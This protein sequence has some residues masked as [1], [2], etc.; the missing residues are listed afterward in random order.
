MPLLEERGYDIELWSWDFDEDLA[1][2][3]KVKK[4]PKILGGGVLGAL[5]FAA[6]SFP[7]AAI[8]RMRRRSSG[9][10]SAIVSV[11]WLCPLA[12]VAIYHFFAPRWAQ[13]SFKIGFEDVRELGRTILTFPACVM[14]IVQANNPFCGARGAVS[15]SVADEI[16]GAT[17]GQRSSEKV[18]VLPNTYDIE[19]FNPVK[20]GESRDKVR[21]EL[22]LAD[23]AVVTGFCSQG[24]HRRKGFW[25]HVKAVK[26]LVE[27]GRTGV[28]SVIVGGYPDTV[29]RLETRLSAL[30]PEYKPYFTFIGNTPRP[31]YYMAAFDLF[32]FPSYFEAFCLAE[33]ECAA[34][35]IPLYL[36]RHHGSEMILD[37]GK[38]GELISYKPEEIADCIERAFFEDGKNYTRDIGRT[39]T[40][41]GFFATFIEMVEH[42]QGRR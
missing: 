1:A 35:G 41:E 25:L 6:T 26:S 30:W 13:I 18:W 28:H 20:R 36:T 4:L 39:A 16:A 37:G 23:D 2:R 42:A 17:F 19:K 21:A 3:F 14:D 32:L 9:D 8:H 38:N 31:E 29:N 24:H 5:S 15:E 40:P 11:A 33:I 22:N 10:K 7:V 34:M 12:D 27:R